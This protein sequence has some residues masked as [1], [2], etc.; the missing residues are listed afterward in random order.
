MLH[1]L[2]LTSKFP[3]FY[4]HDFILFI[5]IS[6]NILFGFQTTDSGHDRDYSLSICFLMFYIVKHVFKLQEIFVMLPFNPANC[7]ANRRH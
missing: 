5:F 7:S 3:Y 6:Q 4:L 2:D 1:L